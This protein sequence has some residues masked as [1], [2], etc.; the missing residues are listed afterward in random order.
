MVWKQRWRGMPGTM[1]RDEHLGTEILDLGL[2]GVARG[3][4]VV[5]QPLGDVALLHLLLHRPAHCQPLPEKPSSTTLIV[6]A[7]AIV[8]SSPRLV[9]IHQQARQRKLTA[10]P[11]APSLLRQQ[12]WLSRSPAPAA[13][14]SCSPCSPPL[15][16]IRN[17]KQKNHVMNIDIVLWVSII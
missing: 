3:R 8:Q 12:Q 6:S 4:G 11:A 14:C 5:S 9:P 13:R 15:S 7:L 16:T 1:R 10:W 2:R 17:N